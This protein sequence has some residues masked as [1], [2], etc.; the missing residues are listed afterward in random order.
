MLF[1]FGFAPKAWAYDFSLAFGSNT[2]YFNI[3]SGTTNVELTYPATNASWNGFTQPTGNLNL[4]G[5]VTYNGTIYT[6]TQIGSSAFGGCSG[7]TAISIPNTMTYVD[8][9]AFH[10]CT[11]LTS[12]TINSNAVA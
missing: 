12:V 8:S 9:Y 10:G 6:V 7:I 5:T 2:L 3:I 4:P 11:G 1:S